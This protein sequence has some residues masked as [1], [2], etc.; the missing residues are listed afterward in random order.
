MPKHHK[1]AHSNPSSSELSY[2][3]KV[4]LTVLLLLFLYPV[5][6]ILMWVWGLWPTWV[7]VLIS[8]P[9]LFFILVIVGLIAVGS[10]VATHRP[11][12]QVHYQY[13]YQNST[14]SGNYQ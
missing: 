2:D 14:S 11:P 8:L 13:Q 9:V 10:L 6:L 3:T 5:G 7:K 4:V 1:P 12:T